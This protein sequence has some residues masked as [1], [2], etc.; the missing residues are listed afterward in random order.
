[1]YLHLGNDKV[2]SGDSVIAIINIEE[3]LSADLCDIIEIAQIEKKIINISLY[4]KKKSLVLCDDRIYISPISSNTLFK[5]S[6]N[7]SKEV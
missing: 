3:P 4:N 1:M 2:I 5:R 6:I 7:F